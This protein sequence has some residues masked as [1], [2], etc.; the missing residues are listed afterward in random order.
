[1]QKNIFFKKMLEFFNRKTNSDKK[2]DLPAG[3]FSFIEIIHFFLLFLLVFLLY[4]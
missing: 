4:I 2:T 3:L 1:M